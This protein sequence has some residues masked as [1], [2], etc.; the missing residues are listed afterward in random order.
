MK[1]IHRV[2]SNK[3]ILGVSESRYR[4]DKDSLRKMNSKV[5]TEECEPMPMKRLD[6]GKE[7]I[8]ARLNREPFEDHNKHFQ[9]SSVEK[10]GY[11][12]NMKSESH[13]YA[14][15]KRL[16]PPGSNINQTNSIEQKYFR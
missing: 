6:Y 7:N 4:R 9:Y 16:A 2:E 13:A 1:V 15:L 12:I 5:L 11:H 14:N 10:N 3:R 8:M